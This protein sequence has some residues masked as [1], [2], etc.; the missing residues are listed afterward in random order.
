MKLDSPPEH[1]TLGMDLFFQDFRV[2]VLRHY[3][4][5]YDLVFLGVKLSNRALRCLGPLAASCT[6]KYVDS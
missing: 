6:R 4:A 1:F 5:E 2:P 3:G